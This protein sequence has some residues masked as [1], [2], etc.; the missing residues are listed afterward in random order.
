MASAA[1]QASVT[2][3]AFAFEASQRREKIDQCPVSSPDQ[4]TVGMLA[5][6]VDVVEGLSQR[7][8]LL[9]DLRMGR[10]SNHTREDLLRQ[11]ERRLAVED[12]MQPGPELRMPFCVSS[13]GVH[14][15]VHIEQDHEKPSMTSSR[16]LEESRS[17]PA[18]SPPRPA[19]GSSNGRAVFLEGRSR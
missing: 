18:I 17:T 11:R 3:L 2:R 10:Q 14:Q 9:E 16:A 6:G 8:R 7:V 4:A 19:T 13:E 5:K 12:R 15:H 1:N